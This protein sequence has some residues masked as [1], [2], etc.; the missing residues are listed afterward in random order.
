MTAAGLS[1]N[2]F[3]PGDEVTVTGLPAT[4]GTPQSIVQRIVNAEGKVVLD[5]T[6]PLEP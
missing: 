2:S 6:N 1:R 4:K 5:R 3:K